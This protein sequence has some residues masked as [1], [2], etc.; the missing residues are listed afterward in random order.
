MPDTLILALLMAL[1]IALGVWGTLTLRPDAEPFEA[2][3]E[4]YDAHNCP[5][6]PEL[7]E[8]D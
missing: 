8:D 4:R 2:V 3:V 1:C 6:S 7:R 5:C